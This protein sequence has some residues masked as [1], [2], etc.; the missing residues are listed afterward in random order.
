MP[1]GVPG[2]GPKTTG[3]KSSSTFKKIQKLIDAQVKA[4]LRARLKK[5]LKV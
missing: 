4:E 3:S 2:S 1:K 5:L